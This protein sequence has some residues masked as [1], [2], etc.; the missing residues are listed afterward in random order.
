MKGSSAPQL[1]TVTEAN[2]LWFMFFDLVVNPLQEI[3][4]YSL[5]MTSLHAK[6]IH[7]LRVCLPC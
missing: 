7:G 2:V 6:Q 1:T 3:I 4:L 5:H